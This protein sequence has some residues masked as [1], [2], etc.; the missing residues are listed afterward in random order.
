[1]ALK[2]LSRT[3][4]N[5]DTTG[6]GA[7][8]LT[9]ASAGNNR[10]FGSQLSEGDQTFACALS[11]DGS[12]WEE[13]LY[14]MTSGDLARTAI[15][16]NSAGNTSAVSLA[17]G[18]VFATMP[19]SLAMLLDVLGATR[20]DM[21]V[22]GSTGWKALAP[23]TSGQV[24]TFGTAEPEWHDPT[25]DG[26][27]GVPPSVVQTAASVANNSAAV[28]FSTAPTQGNTLIA[29]G[30]HW[31]NGVV[32]NRGAGWIQLLSTDGNS[33]DGNVIA[34]KVCGA[35]ESTTQTPFTASVNGQ[36]TGVFEVSGMGGP[37][38]M[39][40]V[41][42]ESAG[43][44]L[45][46][47]SFNVETGLVVGGFS[48]QG[49][50]F[51]FTLAGQD[52]IGANVTGTTT[53][54]SPRRIK[55]WYVD[56]ADAAATVTATLNSGH[57]S[58]GFAIF[59]PGIANSGGTGLGASVL[60]FLSNP[61]SANLRT[62]MTDE[63]GTGAAVFATSPTL[64]TP[65]LGTPASGT[66]TNATGLPVSTGITGMGTNVAGFLTTPSSANLAAAL[67][68]ETGTGVAVFNNS[69]TLIT[70]ALGTPASATLTNATGLPISS[71]VSGLGTG[72]ATFLGTPNSA[73]LRAAMTDESGTGVL[74]FAGGAIGTP[75]SGTLTNAV[76][77]PIST[78]L[79]GAAAGVIT[80]LGTPSS[81]NLAA[82]ITDETGSGALVFG[83]S[84]TL[85]TPALGT[86]A[87]ATLTNA[88]GLP[89]STGVSGLASGVVAL[90]GTPSSANLAAALT[91]ETG[92]GAAVFATSPTL[93]TPALGTPASGTLTN[94]TGLPIS[95][96]VSGLASGVVTLLGTPSSANL[97]AAL[98]D[99]TGS[100][101]AVF[102][103]SPVLT[104]PTLGAASATS[105]NVSNVGNALTVGLPVGPTFGGNTVFLGVTALGGA[106][107]GLGRMTAD[108]SGPFWFFGK[109][110]ATSMSTAAAV[111]AADNLGE[112]DWCGDDGSTAGAIPITAAALRVLAE[113]TIST[114]VVPARFEVRTRD[115]SSLA[116]R[117]TVFSTGGV[118][119]GSGTT[120]DPGATNFAATGTVQAKSFKSAETTFASRPSSPSTGDLCNIS[121]SNTATW[122][123]TVAGSG[124]NH[125]LARWNGSNWT[126][127]GV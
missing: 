10:T 79:T 87:S 72:V 116:T 126:V 113:G 14:T 114:G 103:T 35:S 100:G 98:T 17:G 44:T 18:R 16:S 122:G 89:I 101:A 8:N 99:E 90:L 57:D 67:T 91:D 20:G 48:V 96:G 9:G 86:P 81:A 112:L 53:S 46:L 121:D 4:E 97:A 78:G 74:L 11:G 51:D 38:T 75:A 123:A 109:S 77:L 2:L 7:I 68:D 120:T 70:P 56:G 88:T 115:S 42:Q 64:V 28:T 36:T 3:R 85:V 41:F 66:L 127:V 24:V 111:N 15:I 76:G 93:V 19:S 105:L 102:A 69:P 118:T 12:T 43:S 104:T 106:R 65:A 5:T 82:A 119:V 27:G 13:G 83:T 107:A 49:S 39:A 73:N 63:T 52:A 125:V 61:T 94:A 54:N 21:L 71:G 1:L 95:T 22:R 40:H 30:T 29:I 34:Y 60:D 33:T 47:N 6:T 25:I 45:T 31:T 37:P 108:A 110:R 84:P 117:F 23:G 59:V 62:A 55:L 92:S 32:A 50:N 80:M 58:A 26:I 124:S